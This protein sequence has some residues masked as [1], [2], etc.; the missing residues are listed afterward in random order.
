MKNIF[1]CQVEMDLIYV[2]SS[3]ERADDCTE[4]IEFVLNT[5]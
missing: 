5:V 2:Y 1:I 3:N 4:D